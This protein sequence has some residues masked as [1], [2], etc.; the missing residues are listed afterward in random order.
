M[1]NPTKPSEDAMIDFSLFSRS[2]KSF[3]TDLQKLRRDI[4]LLE[5]ERED[6]LFAPANRADVKA[7]LGAWI[8]RR[9]AAYR[10]R[11]AIVVAR[12]QNDA[13]MST[14]PHAVDR[15]MQTTP[16]LST[17]GHVAAVDLDTAMAGMCAEQM[18]AAL[19]EALNGKWPEGEGLPNAEREAAVAKIDAKLQ[20]LRKQHDDLV[21]EA[22]KHGLQ[23][24]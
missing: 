5:R 19:Q 14:D 24:D 7:A 13:Q 9:Q 12:L 4:E 17:A 8:Q 3:A 21:A 15:H 16:L 22:A 20:K 11:F 10:D 1:A 23:V 2:I 18:Q 6:V